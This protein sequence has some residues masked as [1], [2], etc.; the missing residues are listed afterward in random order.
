MSF[1]T[2]QITSLFMCLLLG[3]FCKPYKARC[4]ERQSAIQKKINSKKKITLKNGNKQMQKEI[5]KASCHHHTFVKD[6]ELYI[7]LNLQISNLGVADNF[8]FT[9]FFSR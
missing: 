6:I 1:I 4:N 9:V 2:S 8:K 5:S 3:D 7:I